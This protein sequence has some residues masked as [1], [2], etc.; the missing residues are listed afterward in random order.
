MRLCVLRSLRVK[1][2]AMQAFIT[3][4]TVVG[5]MA[6]SLAFALLVEEL[7]FGQV[8]PLLLGPQFRVRSAQKR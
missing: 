3:L 4:I 6:L 5:G 7:I 8:F 2:K 1:E